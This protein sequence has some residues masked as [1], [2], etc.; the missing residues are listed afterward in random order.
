MVAETQDLL[1]PLL[2]YLSQG[3][4]EPAQQWCDWRIATIGGGVELEIRQVFETEDFAPVLTPEVRAREEGLRA[5]ME[6][7]GLPH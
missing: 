5:K 4:P 6:A 1:L 3:T 2:A 7:S